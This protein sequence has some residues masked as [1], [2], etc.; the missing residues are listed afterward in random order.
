MNNG[1]QSPRRKLVAVMLLLFLLPVSVT[2]PQWYVEPEPAEVKEA[3]GEP[4]GKRERT[5]SQKSLDEFTWLAQDSEAMFS[6]PCPH[7][8]KFGP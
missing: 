5:F 7:Q 1:C 2:V 6:K 8:R 3:S 4:Q